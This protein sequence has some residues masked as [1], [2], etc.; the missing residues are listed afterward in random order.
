MLTLWRS[1]HWPLIDCES[2]KVWR[3]KLESSLKF[4]SFV[5]TS[6][7]LWIHFHSLLSRNYIYCFLFFHLRASVRLVWIYSHRVWNSVSVSSRH[8]LLQLPSPVFNFQ[9]D[10]EGAERLKSCWNLQII[11]IL[12]ARFLDD[13]SQC[14]LSSSYSLLMPEWVGRAESYQRWTGEII[15]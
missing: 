9:V 3:E 1:R 12:I 2:A 7:K 5:R 11:F 13:S 15:T 6:K 8:S 14:Q 4:M 10:T